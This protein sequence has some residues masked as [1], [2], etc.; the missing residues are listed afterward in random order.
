MDDAI[1]A[2]KRRECLRPQQAMGIGNR[3]NGLHHARP[4]Y[5][6]SRV[7]HERVGKSNWNAAHIVF[8]DGW[9]PGKTCALHLL[10]YLPDI[11]VDLVKQQSRFTWMTTASCANKSCISKPTLRTSRTL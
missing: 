5:K 4:D 2:G 7:R 6:R 3:A 1:A 8:A 11:R 10:L 9:S